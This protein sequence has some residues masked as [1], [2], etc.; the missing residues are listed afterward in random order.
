MNPHYERWNR[1]LTARFLQGRGR[2][3]L[4]L[5]VDDAVIEEVAGEAGAD[6]SEAVADFVLAVRSTLG[7]VQPFGAWAKRSRVLPST[8]TPL[9]LAV[10]CFLVLVAVEREETHFSYYPGLNRALGRPADAGA[11]AGFHEHVELLFV[12]FNDWLAQSGHG[13]P[14]AAPT[15][16]FPYVSW[17]LSQAV[18]RPADRALLVRLFQALGLQPQQEWSGQRL[19]KAV[20]P[21]LWT[22]AESASRTRLLDLAQQHR[23]IFESTLAQ[24]YSAWDGS[25]R[26]MSGPRFSNVRLCHEEMSGD[27]WFIG[28]LVPGTEGHAWT[29]G[30]DSGTVRPHK[31]IESMPA[32]L[33]SLVGSGSVGA[34]EDG[35]ALRSPARD[36]RWMSIDMRAGGWAEVGQRDHQSDQLAIVG[37]GAAQTFS[38]IP[39]VVDRGVAP[40][41]AS[42]FY[43]GR[44]VA[45]DEPDHTPD[46]SGVSLHGGL[47]LHGATNTY[48]LS[49]FGA[50]EVAGCPGDRA[51]VGSVE[52]RVVDGKVAING[53]AIGLGDHEVHCDGGAMVRFRLVDRLLAPGTH[54]SGPSWYDDLPPNTRVDVPHRAGPVW[55]LGA[56][57]AAQER[58]VA[59]VR[60]LRN[61][62]LDVTAADVT[63]VVGATHF[64]PLFVV[65][66]PTP[67]KAW[68]TPVPDRL[69]TQDLG[70]DHRSYDRSRARLLVSKL[71]T[72][73]GPPDIQ[74]DREWKRVLAAFLREVHR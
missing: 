66:S 45:V 37:A 14:T 28:P 70:V 5:Y 56:D 52:H 62:G 10:L 46:R 21:R 7:G 55:I 20:L 73:V 54:P 38:S 74:Q 4:Y 48:L 8:E 58:E 57:G 43:V 25:S 6:T 68:V 2:E 15:A 34:I 61:L 29:I 19:L 36:V 67:S 59:D 41:A 17:P 11:P 39:G 1:A 53:P 71:L 16:S 18:V 32:D 24:I 63:G 60:W 33:W 22:S 72:D 65:S 3:P 35:P 42:I 30:S 69:R 9:H 13:S 40:S 51:D 12:R 49:E 23:D 26:A 64:V 44:G 31:G 47:R 50:P 27:W